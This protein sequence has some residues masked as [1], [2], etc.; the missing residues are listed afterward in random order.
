M[1]YRRQ[2]VAEA[3]QVL[4]EQAEQCAH[5]GELLVAG[6]GGD[7][8]REKGDMTPADAELRR[9]EKILLA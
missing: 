3:A 1:A 4:A 2:K 8:L 9:S 5:R 6:G 7:D